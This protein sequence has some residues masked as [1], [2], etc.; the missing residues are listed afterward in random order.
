MPLRGVQEKLNENIPKLTSLSVSKQCFRL[1]LAFIFRL[2]KANDFYCDKIHRSK[3]I[4]S[5]IDL[6]FFLKKLYNIGLTLLLVN[7]L[8]I[9]QSVCKI[10]SR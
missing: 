7:R 6:I 5:L 8:A 3:D 2:E 4:F 9:L 1:K 10:A